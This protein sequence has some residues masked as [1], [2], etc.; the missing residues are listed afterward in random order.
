MSPEVSFGECVTRT[1]F[2]VRFER[3]SFSIVGESNS[4]N[5][6]PRFEL[7]SMRRLAGVMFFKAFVQIAGDSN[8]SFAGM[9]NAFKKINK[10]HLFLSSK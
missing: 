9:G 3:V 1:G 10:F 5:N 6:F 8:I 7:G 2:E 4:N